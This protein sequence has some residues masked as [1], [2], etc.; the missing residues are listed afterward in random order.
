MRV[1]ID[2]TSAATQREGIGRNTRELVRH[3]LS[4]PDHPDL[5]LMYTHQGPIPAVDALAVNERV[6]VHR[7]PVSARVALAAWHKLRLPVP[8]EAL[9][10]PVHVFHG[11]DFTIP[12]CLVAA[13]VVTVHDLSFLTRPQDA[14]PAQ[15]RFL[16][17]VVPRSI[18]RAR[19]I[20]AISE[21]TKHDLMMRMGVR[22]HRIRVVPTAVAGDFRRVEDQTVLDSVRVRLSLPKEFVLSVG[23]IH[24]RK[25]LGGLAL[26]AAIAGRSRGRPIN[27][28]HAGR[29][30]WLA[31][32]VYAD[33]RDS[34]VP[35]RFLGHVDEATLRVLYSLAS[36]LAFPSYVEGSALPVL[37]AFACGCPVLTSTTSATAEVAGS[38]A[39]L[40]NP[41]D[42]EELAHG[43][44]RILDNAELRSELRQH[45]LD[46]TRQFS[47]ARSAV[48]VL[49]IYREVVRGDSVPREDMPHNR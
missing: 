18:D 24:P 45:G 21:S 3:M 46:R 34:G 39:V 5:H 36:A 23:A 19:V 1:G 4:E 14:H 49:N 47:W 11:P 2:Y 10:G 44:L 12:P 20:V 38:A 30:A 26:A 40:A 15:L 6:R 9:I 31:E 7:I 41:H 43:L 25:N 35:V 48:A 17:S 16:E 13:G 42:P 32:R 37:E 28:V 33:V 29:E 22:P 8:I 27:V